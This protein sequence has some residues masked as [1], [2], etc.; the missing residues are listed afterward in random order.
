[1]YNPETRIFGCTVCGYQ[2]KNPGHAT[3]H[4]EAMHR[5]I[6]QK[7]AACHICGKEFQSVSA[8]KKHIQS[9]HEKRIAGSCEYCG[10]QFTSA[11]ALQ[12][13]KYTHTGNPYQCEYCGQKFQSRHH[14]NELHKKSKHPVEYQNEKINEAKNK[15]LVTKEIMNTSISMGAGNDSFDKLGYG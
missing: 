8:C 2:S 5:N 7:K 3:R 10:K 1:M 14:M 11:S 15:E 6:K 12:K 13:H 9:V 4:V